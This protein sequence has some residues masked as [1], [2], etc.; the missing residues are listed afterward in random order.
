[1]GHRNGT[2]STVTVPIEAVSIQG[3]F[4]SKLEHAI[5]TLQKVTAP[6]GVPKRVDI[7]SRGVVQRDDLR[8]GQEVAGPALIVSS[9][10][11]T[12]LKT[13]AISAALF[14]HRM[15]I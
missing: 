1:M 13:D 15:V 12:S 5:P 4:R 7:T 8:P 2:H 6:I 9:G 14:L 10:S 3:E 11:T